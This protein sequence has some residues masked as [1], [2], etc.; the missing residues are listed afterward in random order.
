MQSK[1]LQARDNGLLVIEDGKPMA[2][3][4]TVARA[5]GKN[6]KDVTRAIR[7]LPCSEVFRGRNFA[8]TSISVQMPNGGV[9]QENAFKMTRDGFSILVMG[10]TGQ[11]AMAWKE[12]FIEAFNT[13]EKQ[14]HSGG[15]VDPAD[16]AALMGAMNR[17]TAQI[18]DMRRQLAVMA[19][20]RKPAGHDVDR[21]DSPEV[22]IVRNYGI[23]GPGHRCLK[24]R[25]Y[26]MYQDCCRAIGCLP[27]PM[28]V[29][30]KGLYAA[31]PDMRP[32]RAKVEGAEK[33]RPV[34][35]GLTI[36]DE[37]EGK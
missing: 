37:K 6:H 27:S 2:F 26:A 29:V 36:K 19:N 12:R 9:R 24:E 15:G 28:A 16:W 11:K 4:D 32:G 8:P 34:I 22:A 30:M 5:F 14:L 25:F 35:V 7:D 1:G 20:D 31:F 10:F 21:S 13:M 3:S 33:P 18:N 17:Q 23:V